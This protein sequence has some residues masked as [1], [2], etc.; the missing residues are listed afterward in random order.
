M[1]V[2]SFENATQ[3]FEALDPAQQTAVV[4]CM[5]DMV[6]K[7]NQLKEIQQLAAKL[8][9]EEKTQLIAQLRDMTHDRPDTDGQKG[10]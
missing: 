1:S 10:G 2:D 4:E 5:R 7:E 8:T 6:R 9:A 3:L